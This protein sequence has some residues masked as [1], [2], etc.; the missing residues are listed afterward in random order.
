[1]IA[2]SAQNLAMVDNETIIVSGHG[3]IGG[4]A[5]LVEYDVMLTWPARGWPR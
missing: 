3:P 2:A 4:K 5:D 1:M